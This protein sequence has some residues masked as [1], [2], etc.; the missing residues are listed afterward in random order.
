[1]FHVKPSSQAQ[2]S[3]CNELDGTWWS[4]TVW[5]RTVWFF[6]L[7]AS[8][9]RL[10]YFTCDARLLTMLRSD[11]LSRAHSYFLTLSR[12]SFYVYCTGNSLTRGHRKMWNSVVMLWLCTC[13]VDLGAITIRQTS[14]PA[15]GKLWL[16]YHECGSLIS[17]GVYIWLLGKEKFWYNLAWAKFYDLLSWAERN[18]LQHCLYRNGLGNKVF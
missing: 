15:I 9:P 5:R 11:K 2:S 4:F 1:V 18:L 6:L 12:F 16:E 7:I 8:W 3:Y 14:R 13:W 10:I 17:L